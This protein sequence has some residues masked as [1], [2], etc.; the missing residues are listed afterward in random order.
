[1]C[2]FRKCV[3]LQLYWLNEDHKGGN[4]TL[5]MKDCCEKKVHTLSP[6]RLHSEDYRTSDVKGSED[7]IVKKYS[8]FCL[9]LN[10]K[11]Q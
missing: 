10:G 11:F 3:R 4:I 5:L 1:M 9:I 6:F 8:R 2:F 7:I